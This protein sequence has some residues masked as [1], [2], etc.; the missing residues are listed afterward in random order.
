MGM[1]EEVEVPSRAVGHVIGANHKGIK[2]IELHSGAKASVRARGEEESHAHMVFEGTRTQVNAAKAVFEQK[3][4][5]AIGAEKVEK[6][7]KHFNSEFLAKL[8]SESGTDA[9]SGGVN[10]LQEFA[11]KWSLKA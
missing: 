1:T 8:K 5:L 2:E 10:G 9:A 11:K 4:V 7:Q 6:L 3:L